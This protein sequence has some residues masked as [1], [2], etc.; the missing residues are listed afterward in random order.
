MMLHSPFTSSSSN[1]EQQG[2]IDVLKRYTLDESLREF[3]II[4]I[5]PGK[6]T[7]GN[8]FWDSCLF[9]IHA[10]NM[11]TKTFAVFTDRDG[12]EIDYKPAWIGVY[13]DGSTF[14]RFDRM[15]TFDV[16]QAM[17]LRVA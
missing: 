2:A 11:K 6:Y 10:Y 15:I 16:F 17:R 4:H 1:A 3:D 9:D 7:D 5:Y 13:A 14:V 12:I 8:G